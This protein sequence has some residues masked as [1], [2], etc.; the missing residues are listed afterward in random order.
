MAA[1]NPSE[2]YK[3]SILSGLSPTIIIECAGRGLHFW[4][5][6]MAQEITYQAFLASSLKGKYADLG[7]HLEAVHREATEETQ[8]LQGQIHG[9]ED[10]RSGARQ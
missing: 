3:T 10:A 9:K 8:K 2:D 1:L 4:A 7:A 6:Q 5:Y